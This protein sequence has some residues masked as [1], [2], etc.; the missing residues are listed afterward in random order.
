MHRLTHCYLVDP[1]D[2]PRLAELNVVAD[3]QLSPSS[4]T[5]EYEESLL[6]KIGQDRVAQLLPAKE[7]VEAGATLVLSSDWDA[8]DLPPLGKIQTVLTRSK[9]RG[10]ADVATVLP[11][12]TRNPATLLDSNAGV[13][14]TGKAADVIILSQ[15]ILELPVDRIG[16]TKVLVTIFDGKVIYDPEGIAGAPIGD[17]PSAGTSKDALVWVPVM[18]FLAVHLY[19]A[20]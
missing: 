20:S 17:A 3:M 16:V 14:K 11:L 9:G 4:L 12:L 10:L 2:R 8:D 7:L 1:V 5:D 6:D 18:L 15:N 13:L 19:F